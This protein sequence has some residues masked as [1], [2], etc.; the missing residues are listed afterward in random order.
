MSR[1]G[2]FDRELHQAGVLAD[3]T[4]P[5]IAAVPDCATDRP[6]LADTDCFAGGPDPD[7]LGDAEAIG[8]YLVEAKLLGT[9]QVLE[10]QFWHDTQTTWLS[11][12]RVR[13]ANDAPC[14]ERKL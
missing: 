8:S 7:K 10:S 6:L 12:H 4:E 5:D 2:S 9:F 1:Q 3:L 11:D 14:S 13:V